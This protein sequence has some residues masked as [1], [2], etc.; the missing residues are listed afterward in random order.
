[1]NIILN[2]ATLSNSTHKNAVWELGLAGIILYLKG[3]IIIHC[4]SQL[5]SC[6]TSTGGGFDNKSYV[7]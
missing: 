4:V 7:A 3:L 1:M 6:F 5:Y 2:M